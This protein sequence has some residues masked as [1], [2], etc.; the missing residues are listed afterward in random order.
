MEEMAR[1]E[2]G[3][4]QED[5]VHGCDLKGAPWSWSLEAE[6]GSCSDVQGRGTQTGLGLLGGRCHA[7]E[8]VST[9]GSGSLEVPLSL[10][11]SGVL[12]GTGS[13]RQAP[14]PLCFPIPVSHWQNLREIV[15]Q[16][17]K[18]CCYL[19]KTLYICCFVFVEISPQGKFLE[20]L[21]V[22]LLDIAIF[23]SI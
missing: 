8:A 18:Q 20:R 13:R 5:I 17:N 2:P 1:I 15:W 16:W 21:Y 23:F 4:F 9:N 22:A 12:T 19:W 11:C 3:D 6:Q 7:S 14:S 10:C